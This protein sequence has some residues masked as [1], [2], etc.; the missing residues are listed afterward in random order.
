MSRV[1]YVEAVVDGLTLV[2]RAPTAS[3]LITA[4]R[5]GGADRGDEELLRVC[6]VKI[7]DTDIKPTD[8][9]GAKAL[10][11]H[12]PG[13]AYFQA[14]QAVQQLTQPQPEHLEQILA[15]ADTEV[16]EDGERHAFM[17]PDT[18]VG[19]DEGYRRVVMVQQPRIKVRE[20]VQRARQGARSGEAQ[21]ILAAVYCLQ[22]SVVQIGEQTWPQGSLTESDI[23]EHLLASDVLLLAAAWNK[24]HLG[25]EGGPGNLRAV[26]APV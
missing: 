14:V 4:T 12:L 11:K 10:D 22:A 3:Q 8:L 13:R 24:V 9:L 6:V 17:L 16:G 1:Y 18:R 5:L 21:T 20:A 15:Y 23:D 25:D 2:L 26:P 19:L 7:G